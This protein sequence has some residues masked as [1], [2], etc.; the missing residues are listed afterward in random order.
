MALPVSRTMASW[1]HLADTITS[2]ILQEE[3]DA[4]V[5]VLR[6]P[7]ACISCGIG[8][9]HRFFLSF[10]CW[11]SLFC[12]LLRRQ[13]GWLLIALLQ[14]LRTLSYWFLYSVQ[15]RAD[16]GRTAKQAIFAGQILIIFQPENTPKALL[17]SSSSS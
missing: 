5:E 13:Q 11:P 3:D 12:L 14:R 1:L 8:I 6:T 9:W 4:L 16:N 15:D 2:W 7:Y 10:F 17:R